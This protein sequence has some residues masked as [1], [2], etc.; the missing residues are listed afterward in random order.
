[1]SHSWSQIKSQGSLFPS[2]NIWREFEKYIAK[3][4]AY[5]GDFT[6]A[7]KV[8]QISSRYRCE[9]NNSL[10]PTRSR[11]FYLECLKM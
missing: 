1:M 11:Y 5:L 9:S 2:P 6:D 10:S 4:S 7:F 8:I 3:E